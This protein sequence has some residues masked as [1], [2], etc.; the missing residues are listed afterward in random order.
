MQQNAYAKRKTVLFLCGV[1]GW[2]GAHNFYLKRYLFGIIY[3]FTFGLLGFG[4]LYDLIRID[5]LL[6]DSTSNNEFNVKRHDDM[7]LITIF[8]GFTGLQHF[9]LKRYTCG[10][11]FLLTFGGLGTGWIVDIFRIHLLTENYNL[12]LFQQADPHQFTLS[13]AYIYCIPFGFLGAHHFYLSRPKWGLFYLFTFGNFGI[14]WLAD[15]IRLRTIVEMDSRE[16]WLMSDAFILWFPLGLFGAHWLY[17]NQKLRAMAYA[18]TFGYLGIGWLIDIQRIPV[19]IRSLNRKSMLAGIIH[20]EDAESLQWDDSDF[21][22]SLLPEHPTLSVNK[23]L[24]VRP[25]PR[26]K[27]HLSRLPSRA[28]CLE[29]GGTGVCIMPCT[30]FS[31]CADCVQANDICPRCSVQIT[32]WATVDI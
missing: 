1:L 13:D 10:L 29:C 8:L 7:K 4:W 27:V 22:S 3:L 6:L 16:K 9:I 5:S 25:A 14:G 30:H 18:F 17:L 26:N 15:I 31:L 20:A 28:V 24:V 11:Y 2:C 23:G 21:S 19:H 12:Q 32:G